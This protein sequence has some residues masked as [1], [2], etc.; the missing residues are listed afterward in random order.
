MMRCNVGWVEQ[1]V[2]LLLGLPTAGS[3]FYVRHYSVVWS[4]ALLILGV[5]FLI[6]AIFRRCPIHHVLGTSTAPRPAELVQTPD[7]PA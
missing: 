3:Y 5:T 2:R 6:T 4:V 7:I 1:V